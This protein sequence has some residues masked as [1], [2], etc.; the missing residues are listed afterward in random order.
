M[1][2]QKHVNETQELSTRNETTISNHFSLDWQFFSTNLPIFSFQIAIFLWFKNIYS[3]NLIN[4]KWSGIQIYHRC[5][6]L[7][8]LFTFPSQNRVS[9]VTSQTF[10]A[11]SSSYVS[12]NSI[13]DCFFY[14]ERCLN[15]K[16]KWMPDAVMPRWKCW[17]KN[18]RDVIYI[19]LSVPINNVT[20]DYIFKV[21]T[22][23]P[24][25]VQNDMKTDVIMVTER[26]VE[27][28]R[29]KIRNRNQKWK[30]SLN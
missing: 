17:V 6:K 28:I 27:N 22:V 25:P 9:Y 12:L 8:E 4:E 30:T 14:V 5:K 21:R 26:N 1:V 16:W 20:N 7:H 19:F 15:W 18:E 3:L 23:L 10:Q 24:L 29:S 13:L 2:C 11:L